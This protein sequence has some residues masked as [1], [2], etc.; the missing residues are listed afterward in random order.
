M[1][2]SLG[3]ST[4]FL[5]VL[6]F[7]LTL[8]DQSNCLFLAGC[9]IT[10]QWSYADMI[11]PGGGGGR[12][13]HGACFLPSASL[14]QHLSHS[15]LSAVFSSH[16]QY[17]PTTSYRREQ[18]KPPQAFKVFNQVRHLHHKNTG[19]SINIRTQWF[20]K[21]TVQWVLQC[22]CLGSYDGVKEKEKAHEQEM[23]MEKTIEG[24]KQRTSSSMLL[25]AS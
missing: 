20:Q 11:S 10:V 6:Q 4:H 25:A 1:S 19:I 5:C 2:T 15:L 22:T 24:Q 13:L 16:Y 17:P 12:V 8:R 21:N 14:K 9:G 3:F 23:L 18:F 7:P